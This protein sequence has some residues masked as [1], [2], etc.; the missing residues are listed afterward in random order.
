MKKYEE[1]QKECLS[2]NTN[3]NALFNKGRCLMYLNK[4]DEALV[5]IEQAVKLEPRNS[6]FLQI[7]SEILFKL[8]KPN[9]ALEYINR[10]SQ[11]NNQS[12]EIFEIKGLILFQLEKENEAIDCFM[13]AINTNEKPKQ[14]ILDKMNFIITKYQKKTHHFDLIQLKKEFEDCKNYLYL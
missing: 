9:E 3:S 4:L 6:D 10:A 14:D 1:A 12:P 13:K 11:I 5:Q 7:K 8:N 2:E